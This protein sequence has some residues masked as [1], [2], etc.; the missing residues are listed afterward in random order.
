[1]SAGCDSE[2]S[3][4]LWLGLLYLLDELR[5]LS[6]QPVLLTLVLTRTS[7]TVLLMLEL[8]VLELC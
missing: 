2:R 5:P 1:V 4:D 7:V 8:R 6:I 3:N